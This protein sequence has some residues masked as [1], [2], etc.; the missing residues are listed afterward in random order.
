[1][2]INIYVNELKKSLKS[3]S[4]FIFT[5]VVFYGVYL[6]VSTIRPGVVFMGV[7]YGKEWHNAPLIIARI[8]TQLSV[9]GALITM[10]IVGR[11]VTKD[12]SAKIHDFFF[13]A[14]ISKNAYLGGRFLGGLTANLLIFIGVVL[15]FIVGCSVL[16]PD[17]YGPFQISD[18][19]LRLY[20]C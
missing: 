16:E 6:F 19:L 8:F 2:F 17:Y 7:G 18:F 3:I 4:F 1:M 12:F 10:V 5:A 14:P 13:T 15:G 11:T 9:F 20:S